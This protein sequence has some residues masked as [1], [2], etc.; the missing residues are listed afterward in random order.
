[1]N[2]KVY[3]EFPGRIVLI[4]FGSIGQGVLPLIL[5]HI[6]IRPERIS[7]V[8]ADDRGRNVAEEYVQAIGVGECAGAAMDVIATILNDAGT[9]LADAEQ[10]LREA[11]WPGVIYN[12]YAGMVVSAKALLLAEDLRCNS[13][14]KIIE[15]FQKEFVDKG[16]ITS[17]A[18]FVALATAINKNEPSEDFARDYLRIARAFHEEAYDMRAA[19][20]IEAGADK[21]VIADF[22]RA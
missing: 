19:Q 2:D 8:T 12:A 18:D 11:N 16:L 20:L 9:K 10:Y 5:R 3:F 22:Y 7:I 17:T 1:M 14:Q 15:D 6:G 4:G 21:A 13:H